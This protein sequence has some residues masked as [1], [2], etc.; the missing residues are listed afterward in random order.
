MK[1]P[2][3]RLRPVAWTAVCAILSLLF[4]AGAG[5][6][7]QELLPGHVP[8]GVSRLTPIGALDGTNRLRLVIGLPMR[9]RAELNALL[10]QLYDP[11]SP[12]YRHYVTAAEFAQKFGPTE[13]DYQAVADFASSNNLT[14]TATHPN[15]TLVDVEGSV[16]DIDRV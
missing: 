12:N 9:N 3:L 1:Q 11:T 5:A 7:G 14:V 4:Q 2:Y 6:A 8:P 13:A 16:A 10:Q 15:R